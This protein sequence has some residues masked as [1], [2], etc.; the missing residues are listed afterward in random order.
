MIV[1][2]AMRAFSIPIAFALAA[3]LS[4]T[5]PLGAVASGTS[6]RVVAL[7]AIT[8]CETAWVRFARQPGS[9]LVLS[10]TNEYD[11]KFARPRKPDNIADY[12]ATPFSNDNA[13]WYKNMR[14]Y[15]TNVGN[16]RCI[17]GFYDSAHKTALIFSQNGTGSDLTL[18]TVANA[19]AGLPIHSAPSQTRN[20]VRLGMTVAQVEAIDGSGTLR[21]DGRYQRLMYSQD[22]KKTPK[23]SIVFYLGF[24]FTD[25]KLVAADVGGGV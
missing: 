22:I 9:R 3:E 17:S 2:A 23:F 5:T 8:S 16:G 19:P 20:G 11:K 12:N 1:R 6:P 18:T 14:H 15:T 10:L 21:A 7:S 25:G 24:L 13:S 4:A